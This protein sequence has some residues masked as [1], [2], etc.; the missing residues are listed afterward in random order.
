MGSHAFPRGQGKRRKLHSTWRYVSTFTTQRTCRNLQGRVLHTHPVSFPMLQLYRMHRLASREAIRKIQGSQAQQESRFEKF[1]K[2]SPRH[3]GRLFIGPPDRTDNN[4]QLQVKQKHT[5]TRAMLAFLT[6]K[7][8]TPDFFPNEIAVSLQS[9]FLW[10]CN[11]Y[12]RC[13]GQREI[14][15]GLGAVPQ[16][17]PHILEGLH[18]C[19]RARSVVRA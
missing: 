14:L 17:L 15:P 8:E 10:K 16:V 12:L 3:V 6:R 4:Q 18:D 19:E 7:S 13:L 11:P 5:K 9:I 2:S 1:P